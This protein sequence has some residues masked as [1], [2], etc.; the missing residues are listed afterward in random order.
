MKKVKRGISIFLCVA[1]LL[2]LLSAGSAAASGNK[3]GD[4][5]LDGKVDVSD[6]V[7]LRMFIFNMPSDFEI[8]MRC[9]VNSDGRVDISDV[10]FLRNIIMGRVIAMPEDVFEVVISVEETTLRQGE[11]FK[12]DVELKNKTDKSYE[13]TYDILFWPVIPGWLPF[14][15][16]EID[17]PYPVSRTIEPNGVIQNIG[18]WQDENYQ[19]LIGDDLEPGTHELTF[20]ANFKVFLIGD[21]GEQM[22]QTQRIRIYSNPVMLT[23]LED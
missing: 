1:M 19:W 18:P 7:M 17:L 5:D 2:A 9:D 10:I 22:T 14:H 3:L 13:I 8:R 12:V 4:I 16:G 23:V 15:G 11:N 6:V 20:Y 21:S